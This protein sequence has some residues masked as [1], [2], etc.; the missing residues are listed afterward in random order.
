MQPAAESRPDAADV[1]AA[2]RLTGYFLARHVYEPRNLDMPDARAKLIA[3]V[4]R[5]AAAVG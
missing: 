2:F 5:E 4:A 3:L 1:A